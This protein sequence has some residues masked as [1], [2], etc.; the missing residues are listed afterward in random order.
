[1]SKK[2][3]ILLSVVAAVAAIAIVGVTVFVGYTRGYD[4]ESEQWVYVGG[5][6]SPAEE[7]PVNLN[8]VL[9]TRVPRPTR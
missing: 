4:G 2:S 7:W 5:N 3:I 6:A 9:A 1:M 8:S